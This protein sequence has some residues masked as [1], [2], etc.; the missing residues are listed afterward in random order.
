[1]CVIMLILSIALEKSQQM[2]EIYWVASMWLLSAIS[3]YAMFKIFN[4]IKA[5]KNVGIFTNTSF[6]ALYFIFVF[7]STVC[8]TIALILDEIE[9][10]NHED[11]QNHSAF[12]Y[13]SRIAS[14]T[15][16]II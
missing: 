1:M 5:L 13:R 11:H 15:F 10:M 14:R 4:K 3:G 7:G 12:F 2:I 6:M 9:R 16:M 8:D